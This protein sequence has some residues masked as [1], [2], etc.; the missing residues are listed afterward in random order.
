MEDQLAFAWP[1]DDTSLDR[2]AFDKSTIIV[3][4]GFGEIVEVFLH[5]ILDAFREVAGQETN[6]KIE[7]YVEKRLQIV[8][9]NNIS[10][11]TCECIDRLE[12]PGT[13]RRHSKGD[14]CAL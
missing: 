11:Q 4:I 12:L 3:A 7:N 1:L 10:P 9:H 14:E 13:L 8:C 2:G 5:E 6:G